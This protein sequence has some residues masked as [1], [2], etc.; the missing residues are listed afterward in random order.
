MPPQRGSMVDLSCERY[1]MLRDI[2]NLPI[3]E[4]RSV[5]YAI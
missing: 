2:A 5:K 4:I 1:E 3:T